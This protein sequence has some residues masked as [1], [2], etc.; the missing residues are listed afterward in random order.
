MTAIATIRRIEFEARIFISLGIVLVSCLLAVL[1]TPGS[2]SLVCGIGVRVGMRAADLRPAAFIAGA[3]I[4]LLCSLL[5]MWAGTIL[6]ARRVMSFRV[7]SESLNTTGP[8]RLSRNPIYLADFLAMCTFALYLPPIGLLMPVLFF[9]HYM[10]LIRYEE[11]MLARMHGDA[12]ERYLRSAPRL[13][14]TPASLLQLPAALREWRLSA[15]G[16]R[17]NATYVLFIPGLLLAAATDSF[18][19]AVIVGIPAVIDWAVVHTRIGLPAR[20]KGADARGRE[21]ERPA[22]RAPRASSREPKVF[23]SVLYAQCWEDPEIDRAAFAIRSGDTVFTITSGGDNALAFL[24]DDPARVIA[25]DL[26]RH[27]NDMLE[28]KIA[29]IRQ[30]TRAQLLAFAGVH[31]SRDRI[32]T[33]A[34]L[35]PLL[36]P[37][38]AGYWDAHQREIRRGFVHAGCFEGYMRIVRRG[39][40]LLLGCGTLRRLYFAQTPDQRREILRVLDGWRWR[41]ATRLLL[42]RRVMSLLFDKAFFAQLDDDFS[43]GAHFSAIARR[44]FTE[45][46]VQR[47]SFLAYI[48]LGNFRDEAL[49]LW[50]HAQHFE[51]IRERVGR[52]ELVH[53]PCNAYFATLPADSID[54]FNFTNIFEW[55]PDAAFHALLADTIRVGRDGAT[56]TYRNLLVP[57]SRPSS[58]AATLV[59]DRALAERLHAEDL[60]FI[61]RTYVIERIRKTRMPWHS[62]STRFARV[63]T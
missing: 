41:T 60:S 48:L 49:P 45:L 32:G 57:R 20:E 23:R 1:F 13:L 31:A 36:T 56:I 44:A 47:S 7:Q 9:L 22:A 42:S 11:A 2:P 28:L 40:R 16:I 24:L 54:A 5:R 3:V 25:L 61:Y 58:M 12:Y 21:S 51:R 52:I 35:R 55:M 39:L 53:A 62:A 10:Q 4:M 18:L 27:Q 19:V 8:Y 38:A 46:P 14:P 17:H 26:N 59:P 30:L 6:S 34:Q 43:F 15:E 37:D 29:A 33:Y 63:A 50:M